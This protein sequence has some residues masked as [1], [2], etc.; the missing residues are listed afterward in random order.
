MTQSQVTTGGTIPAA[1]ATTLLEDAGI[2]LFDLNLT[3]GESAVSAPWKTMVGLA[4]DAEISPQ[5]ELMARIHPDDLGAFN[6]ADRALFSGETNRSKTTFRLRHN[7]GHWVWVQSD[8]GVT[9]R[10]ADGKPVKISGVHID[11]TER[12]EQDKAKDE[13]V[14][15]ISHEL[16]TPLTSV[17]GA[18]K[19]ANS[20]QLGEVAPAIGNLLGLAQRNSNRLLHLVNEL[21][22]FKSLESGELNYNLSKLDA[23]EVVADA[24]QSIEGYLQDGQTV[25]ANMPEGTDPIMLEV[26]VN[27]LQQILANLLSNAAKFSPADSEIEL[28]L[29][30]HDDNICFKVRDHGPGVPPEL[31]GRMFSRFV[32]TKSGEK[33]KFKSTGLGLSICKQMTEGMGG[34]I[35]Y[36]NNDDNGATFWAK[37][38]LCAA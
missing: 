21:L 18:L 8:A 2:G 34:E 38:P 10:D 7:A 36:F 20:G 11:V 5:D 29:E 12:I 30:L 16:R 3:T 31:E 33:K 14:A 37:F 6:A 9:D 23:R 15:M 28:N 22:D 1:R 32:Q 24:S 13:F 17:L 35:G 25:A 4:P 19:M 26:D 27:R